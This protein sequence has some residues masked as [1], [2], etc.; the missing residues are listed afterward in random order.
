MYKTNSERSVYNLGTL[1][2]AGAGTTASAMMSW[3]LCMVHFPKELKKLQ[4]E[5]DNV[6]GDDRLPEF[7]DMI[8]MPRVRAVVKEVRFRLTAALQ[9]LN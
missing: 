7:E 9:S 1:F 5:V 8:N 2:E 3:M 4:T 6:V